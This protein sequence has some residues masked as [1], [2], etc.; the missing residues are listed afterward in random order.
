MRTKQERQEIVKMHEKNG[1]SV[2]IEVFKTIHENS[3]E[4][5]EIFMGDF[6]STDGV[7]LKECYR[8]SMLKTIERGLRYV[9]G[10]VKIAGIGLVIEHAW[11][12]TEDGEVMDFTANR[13]GFEFEDYFGVEFTVSDVARYV[14]DD[15]KREWTMMC[16]Y[17]VWNRM[18]K[19]KN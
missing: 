5:G 16:E 1:Y 4:Y 10:Y 8:N 11:N 6:G 3:K 15:K 7:N 2:E 12:L 9:E 19:P 17:A 18:L 14:S 13:F